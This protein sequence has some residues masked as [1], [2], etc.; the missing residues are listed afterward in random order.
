MYT[1]SGLAYFS[2]DNISGV[3]STRALLWSSCDSNYN[4]SVILVNQFDVAERTPCNEA[5]QIVP[6]CLVRCSYLFNLKISILN[7]YQE[8]RVE[9]VLISLPT[10]DRNRR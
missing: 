5:G 8:I 2:I 10:A 1:G 9:R 6:I 7:N 4:V 3:V